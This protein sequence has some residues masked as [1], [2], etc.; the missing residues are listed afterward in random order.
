MDTLIIYHGG[1]FDG[2]TAAWVARKV[3]P[4]AEFI[5]MAHGDPIPVV[6]GKRVFILDFSF[7]RETLIDLHQRA[8]SLVLLDHHESAQSALR[9]L[10]FCIFDLNKSGA[11]LTWNYFFPTETPPDLVIYEEDRD[12]ERYLWAG[13]REYHAG[14]S[15]FPFT[16][17]A[18]D[19]IEKTPTKVLRTAGKAILAFIGQIA[20]KLANRAGLIDL[21]LNEGSLRCW[22]ANVPVEFTMETAEIL[23][24]REVEGQ[25]IPVL[26]WSFD[27]E[28]QNYYCS[29]RSAEDGI[30]VSKVAVSL[31]GGG[32]VHASGFRLQRRP[33]E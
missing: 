4:S 25:K 5:P 33:G 31:G 26:C 22:S 20:T 32:H 21:P 1:C 23:T 17:E 2:F 12:L 7:D 10:D 19:E 30:D 13:T 6:D 15:T 8:G 16:W 14:I 28:R 11:G 24:Q 9:G 3:F 27:H 18:W 29:I